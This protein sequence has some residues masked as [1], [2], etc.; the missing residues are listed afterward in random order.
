MVGMSENSIE[1]DARLNADLGEPE[2]WLETLLREARRR[3]LKAATQGDESLAKRWRNVVRGLDTATAASA[4][5]A[6]ISEPSETATQSQAQPAS[7][8]SP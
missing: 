5:D 3:A 6:H 1:G 7:D 4:T 8:S 2:S